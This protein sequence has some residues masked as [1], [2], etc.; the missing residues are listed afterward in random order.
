MTGVKVEIGMEV[1]GV[2]RKK[3]QVS[4]IDMADHVLPGFDPEMA[5]YV[6][7]RLADERLMT[8]TNTKL[9][10]IE[11]TEKI[12]KVLTGRRGIKADAVILSIGIETN[13]AFLADS[14]IE[15]MPNRTIKVDE[16]FRTND[17]NIYAVGICK[18]PGMNVERTGL[19]EQQA[20]ASGC[21]V[22]TVVTVVNDKAHYYRAQEASS[23]RQW[24]R[25]TAEDF[26]D[27]R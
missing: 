3:K 8:F 23:S 24:R 14:G 7:N 13:T 15:L 19:S 6:E 22:E 26:R 9:E 5:E 11:G 27:C 4:V 10:G 20:K 25:K 18:L 2:D 1:T 12:E 17:P 21:Q 16:Y